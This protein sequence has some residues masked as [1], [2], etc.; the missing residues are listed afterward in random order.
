MAGRGRAARLAHRVE[1]LLRARGVTVEVRPTHEPGD[2]GKLTRQTLALS[3]EQRPRCIVVAGG[4]GTIQDVA[5]VLAASPQPEVSARPALG[6]VPA[7][8][9]NDFARALRMP[10]DPASI[11][12]VLATGTPQAVDLGCVNGRYFCT[13]ATAGIDAQVSRFVDRLRMPLRGTPAYIYGALRVLVR[14]VPP[15][16]RIEGDFGRIDKAVFLASTANT[17]SYGGAIEIAPGADPTDGQL[18]LCIIE[19]M[20][21]LRA[22]GLV[23]AVLAR[24]HASWKQVSLLTARHLRIETDT[25]QEIWADGEKIAVTPATIHVAPA[26]IRVMRPRA[27]ASSQSPRFHAPG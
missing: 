11:A 17:S 2:A 8:R 10:A 19:A 20:S 6:L 7:G 26:A 14:F 1:S 21:R 22:L 16:V 23:V 24:R 13:V 4:D 5:N 3:L 18:N 12:E 27:N 25:P 9:C 15:R